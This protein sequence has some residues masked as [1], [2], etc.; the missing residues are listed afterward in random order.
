MSGVT[1]RPNGT[2]PKPR[3]GKGSPLDGKREAK[4]IANHILPYPTSVPSI[5][6][7]RTSK[8]CAQNALQLSENV[9]WLPDQFPESFRRF[10]HERLNGST[11]AERVALSGI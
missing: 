10:G 4:E 8:L 7:D 11:G 3:R 6:K 1:D 9:G 5:H 2:H